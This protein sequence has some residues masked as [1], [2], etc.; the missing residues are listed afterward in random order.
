MAVSVDEVEVLAQNRAFYAAFRQRDLDSMDGLWAQRVK[1]ACVHPGWQ[2][3]RGRE[4]VMA[5]W[6]AILGQANVPQIRCEEAT[7][8]VLGDTAFVL[9]EEVLGEGRLVATNVFIREEGD[10]RL[11]HHQAGPMAPGLDAQE[12]DSDESAMAFGGHEF[13]GGGLLAG[14][15]FGRMG[16]K[17][18]DEE[19]LT[20]E[21][22]SESGALDD[23]LE[24]GDLGELCERSGE[25]ALAGGS[26]AGRG[27]GAGLAADPESR[28][29]LDLSELPELDDTET[30]EV[31]FN[32]AGPASRRLLN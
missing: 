7:A 15:R 21:A 1:V 20:T 10:W 17:G 19:D 5:S 11:V 23:D 22:D 27:R 32:L 28:P 13:P 3:I 14:L 18:A 2:P 16:G 25:D 6:R 26:I 31:F 4:Q 9:C 30:P 24:L 29:R 12:D 8:H